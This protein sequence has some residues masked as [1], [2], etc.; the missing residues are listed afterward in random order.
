MEV[1]HSLGDFSMAHEGF[2][3]LLLRANGGDSVNAREAY[4]AA[5]NWMG[6]IMRE[7]DSKWE[8][9]KWGKT[10]PAL[11]RDS[12]LLTT[13]P[14]RT[15]ESII[16]VFWPV[17]LKVFDSKPDDFSRLS[18][19]SLPVPLSSLPVEEFLRWYQEVLPLA[20]FEGFFELKR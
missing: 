11:S 6:E 18:S 5:R 17:V 8:L 13:A 1:A 4:S 14:V 16:V 9:V 20:E 19:K 7:S 10:N 15:E 3:D 12:Y 2:R